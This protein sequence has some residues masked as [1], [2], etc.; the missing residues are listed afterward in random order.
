MTASEEQQWKEVW[1]LYDL[2]HDSKI[3]KSE[4]LSAV[5]VC[6]RRYTAE[7]MADKTKAF[8]DVVS[9]DTY[10]GFLCDPYS[11]P[12]PDDLKNALR[13]FDGNDCGSLTPAQV[14]SLLTSMGDKMTNAE[15]KPLIDALPVTNGRCDIDRLCALLTP[16]VP[17]TKPN[18]PELMKELMREESEKADLPAPPSHPATPV[19][20]ALKVPTVEVAAP[21]S[22]DG[23]ASASVDEDLGNVIETD[24]DEDTDGSDLSSN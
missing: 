11:G 24:S 17:S 10:F 18:I 1:N 15:V 14:Q 8:G 21:E 2:D 13:A 3:T 22:D 6:G 4:F 9:Y 12:K 19:Q 16:P 7:Q 20:A 23:A 5:R